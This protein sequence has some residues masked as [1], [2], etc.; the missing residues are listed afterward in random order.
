[1]DSVRLKAPA[2]VNLFLDI[3]GERDD[4]YTEIYSLIQAVSLYD[5]IIIERAASG[6]S[7]SSNDSSV[8]LD[9]S[10]TVA[11]AWAALCHLTGAELGAKIHLA[12]RIPTESGLGGGSSDSAS[13]IIGLAKIYDL[14]FDKNTQ[15]AIGA[16]VGSDVPFFFG[17]GCSIVRGRGEIIEDYS[18]PGD[19]ALF[20]VKPPYGMPTARAYSLAKKALTITDRK[21]NFNTL[22]PAMAT[23]E[24]CR[25]GNDLEEAFLSVFPEAGEIKKRLIGAGAEYAGLTGSGSAFFGLFEDM[26]S[27]TRAG[28]KF[29]DMWRTAVE[30]VDIRN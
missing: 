21:S 2:K 24:L 6:L 19:Y 12:K 26:N 7:L 1:M 9:N 3:I 20:L 30:P 13:A 22:T 14:K 27:A 5:E 28:H 23:L 10:N 8:P 18:A 25:R 15:K 4:G 29:R 11:I 16:A 17:T